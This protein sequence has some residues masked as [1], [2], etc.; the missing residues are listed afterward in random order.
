MDFSQ[1]L[2]LI[3]I[4]ILVIAFA[5][6]LLN[7]GTN[8]DFR[9]TWFTITLRVD[10]SAESNS[11]R[12]RLS[13]IPPFSDN[14]GYHLFVNFLNA[15]MSA[16]SCLLLWLLSWLLFPGAN[17]HNGV[18]LIASLVIAP[19]PFI[20]NLRNQLKVSTWRSIRY[21]SAYILVYLYFYNDLNL[22]SDY[23][24]LR[25]ITFGFFVVSIIYCSICSWRNYKKQLKKEQ[26]SESENLIS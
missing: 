11:Y 3:P 10:S 18:L 23:E 17:V 13:Q 24:D 22:Y 19:L 8:I 5:A 25:A 7:K 6:I 4:S 9:S 2:T 26:Q 15:I 14:I 1:P 16:A 20:V 21:L 12:R